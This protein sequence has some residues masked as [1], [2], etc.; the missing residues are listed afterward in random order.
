MS[1]SETWCSTSSASRR[2]SWPQLLRCFDDRASRF[3]LSEG[4]T[5]VCDES[6][7]WVTVAKR[8]REHGKHVPRVRT[9]AE[10]AS[11]LRVRGERNHQIALTNA[12]QYPERDLPIAPYVLGAW[13][14]DGTSTEGRDHL[15]RPRDPRRDRNGRLRGH[16]S[17]YAEVSVSNRRDRTH[18]QPC[19]RALRGKRL[20]LEHAA[21]QRP[22]SGT[23]TFRRSTSV[24]RS[25]SAWRSSRA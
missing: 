3:V 11:T 22:R 12:V 10:L 7:Q 21:S 24:R 15:R 23:S 14:G 8:D 16:E 17:S 19:N 18:A 1:R 4:T 25:I 20:A 6:H 5:I 13:L 9:A 2:S